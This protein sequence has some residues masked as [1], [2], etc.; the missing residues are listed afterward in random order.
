M[1]NCFVPSLQFDKA[2]SQIQMK[3]LLYICYCLFL[4]WRQIE[5]FG[6]VN[7]SLFLSLTFNLILYIETSS[8]RVILILE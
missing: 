4:F 5:E 6:T 3:S 1:L 8:I 7:Q 2:L